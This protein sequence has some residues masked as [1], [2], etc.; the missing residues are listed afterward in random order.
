MS[1]SNSADVVVVGA[2]L[3]GLSAARA[4][5]RAGHSVVVL[6]ARERVGGRT[7]NHDLG[8]G[9]VVEAGGQFVGP[10]QG[11]ILALA[12]ELGVD[13]FPA[14]AE[15]ET[16]YVVGGKRKRY[17]G[18]VPPDLPVLPDLGLLFARLNR[19][20]RRVPVEAPWSAA[21]AGRWDRQTLETWMRRNTLNPRALELFN[22]FLSSAYGGGARDA[23]LLFTLFYIAGFGD[24]QHAGT[25]ER[26]IDGEGG[27]QERRFVGGSQLLSIRMAE[28]LGSVVLRAPVR[29]IEQEAGGVAIVCD[30]GTW[31]AQRVVVSVP[32]PL[33]ARIAWNPVLP[34]GHDALFQRLPMG[35]LMKCEAVYDRPFWREDGLTGQAI[36]P[37]GPIKSTYDN[38]PPEGGP[39]VLM[40]F[41]GGHQW[42]LLAPRPPAE[43]RDI[44]LRAFATAFGPR[45]LE[46]KDYFEQDWT[47]EEW[48]RGGPTS[49]AAPGTLSDF[50]PALGRPFGRVHWAGAE[51]SPYWNGF[52]DGAV[53]SGEHTAAEVEATL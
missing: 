12:E 26:G 43:R 48:T 15:G 29:R 4:L 9:R 20:S 5:T 37:A 46:A 32:P 16:T 45:A 39:G 25:V 40:G 13:T 19:M 49:V 23:S 34:V 51:H 47:T 8:D 53:R 18:V 17:K 44:V 7:L 42:R 28:Q 41:L 31:R 2:G 3:A 22:V 21:R 38:T 50:G 14:Y 1:P 35:T 10:T 36:T 33:A 52:M 6:E 30:A 11:R 24:E 27:A